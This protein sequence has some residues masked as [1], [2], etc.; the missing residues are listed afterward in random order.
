MSDNNHYEPDFIAFLELMWGDGY[1]SPGGA[2]EVGRLL[3]GIDLHGKTVLD[4]GCGSGGI[5]A[6]LAKEYGAAKVVGIDVEEPVC[7]QARE[8]VARAGV[9]DRVEI[10]QVLPANP[11]PIGDETFDIVFSKDSIVHIPDKEALTQD[12]LRILKPG[13]WLVASDWL[14]SH[15]GEPSA[16]MTHYIRLEDLDFGMASPR[17]YRTA[18]DTAGFVNVSL[19]NRNRWYFETAK[20]EL[21][22]MLGSERPQFDATLGK[23]GIDEQIALWQ[24]MLIVLGSGEHCPHHFRG[25]KP[26]NRDT[27]TA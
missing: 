15:D 11:F 22:R 9:G 6:L 18:L 1:L 12:A 23:E 16:E 8:T 27:T 26:L 19:N 3:A 20:D 25:Q 4:I 17:R 13:G 21:Q 2:D 5:T 10:Q 24:A 7:Q 14:I